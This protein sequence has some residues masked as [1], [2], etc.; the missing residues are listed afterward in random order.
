MTQLLYKEEKVQRVASLYDIE[1]TKDLSIKCSK[2]IYCDDY[3]NDEKGDSSDG[4]TGVPS[5]LQEVTRK[6]Y[7][8]RL[9]RF[10]DFIQFEIGIKEIEKRCNDFAEKGKSNINWTLNQIIRFLRFQ[11]ER[12]EK[13]E[14][15]TATLVA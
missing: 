3:K 12:G 1:S 11:K 6:Y 10:F 4:S 2:R 14:K 15:T 8:R 7:E 9:R 13:E 5:S